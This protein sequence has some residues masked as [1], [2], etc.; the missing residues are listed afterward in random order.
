MEIENPNSTPDPVIPSPEPKKSKGIYVLFALLLVADLGVSV[1]TPL[2]KKPMVEKKPEAKT[3]VIKQ[4]S[5]SVKPVTK[6]ETYKNAKYNFSINYPANW[7]AREYPDSKNGAAFRPIGLGD[8]RE[9]ISI[10][11]NN[12]TGN[13]IELPIEEYA[14]KGASVEIQNYNKLSSMKKIM[15][16]EGKTGY[17]TTWMVQPIV[18]QPTEE[19]WKESTPITYFEVPGKHTVVLRVSLD[20]EKYSAL[21]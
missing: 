2:T 18:G 3:M 15:T 19:D 6:W 4:A 10:S 8:D 16:T 9:P 17:M 1:F 20:D 11:V 14:K 12:K 7:E 21:Y 5:P 13:Y